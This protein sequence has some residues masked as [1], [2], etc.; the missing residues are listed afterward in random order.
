MYNSK[1]NKRYQIIINMLLI[2]VTL[3]IILPFLLVFISSITD[4]NTLIREGY[5]FFPKQLSLYAYQ[6]I[7]R[8]GDKILRAYGITIFVTLLG[9][10]VNVTMSAL[11]AYPLSVKTLP[12][13]FC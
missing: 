3:S 7:I 9:T 11:M 5:S 12:Q 6:Y 8:Q 4:E 13:I 2:I 1:K 10:A